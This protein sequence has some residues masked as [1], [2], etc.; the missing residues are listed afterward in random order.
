MFHS[1]IAK[2]RGRISTNRSTKESVVKKQ[3]RPQA[4]RWIRVVSLLPLILIAVAWV[5]IPLVRDTCGRG[6]LL[7]WQGDLPGVRQ[8]A[9]GLGWWAPAVTGIL[10][11]VQAIA[12]PIPAVLV[13]AANS[14]LFG[15]FWG[16]LYSILTANIA[17][18]VCY[19]IGRG[20][21]KLVVDSLVSGATVEKYESFFQK[22][23]TLTVLVS[24]L[25]PIVPFDPISYIAGMVRMPFGKFFWATMIGQFPAGMAYSYLVQTADQPSLFVIYMICF[26]V[27]LT[28]VGI[29]M[30]RQFFASESED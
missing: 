26:V 2:G 17:A 14:F 12:A 7:V 29:A 15:P 28:L 30:K 25:I 11:I 10:M 4:I 8:W 6:L 5:S 27:A 19:G 9:A 1:N 21:G 24:R 20:Y 18:S 16:G 3:G 22:H 23:G 13:T